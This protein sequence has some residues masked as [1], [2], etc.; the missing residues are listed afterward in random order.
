MLVRHINRH[1]LQVPLYQH[2]VKRFQMPRI[3]V[4]AE[5]QSPGPASSYDVADISYQLFALEKRQDAFAHLLQVDIATLEVNKQVLMPFRLIQPDFTSQ[6][7]LGLNKFQLLNIQ[8]QVIWPVVEKQP[9][10]ST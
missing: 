9:E 5:G 10:T 3:I 1:R 8:G 7:D 4:K 6:L 2:A